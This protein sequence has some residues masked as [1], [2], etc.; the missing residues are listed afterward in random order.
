MPE[1]EKIY[2]FQ[3]RI[4]K[5]DYIRL[6]A[7][8]EI[9]EKN[10]GCNLPFNTFLIGHIKKSAGLTAVYKTKAGIR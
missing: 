6:K 8:H 5:T 7:Q 3:L 4:R 10:L 2:K 1:T 9:I